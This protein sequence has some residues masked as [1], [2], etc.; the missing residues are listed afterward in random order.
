MRRARFFSIVSSVIA[1]LLVWLAISP[2]A[3]F[4]QADSRPEMAVVVADSSSVREAEEVIPLAMSLIGLLA[5]QQEGDVVFLDTNRPGE[6]VGP[7]S[8][9]TTTTRAPERDRARLESES[10]IASRHSGGAGR[11]PDRPFRRTELPQVQ[12]STWR[13]EARETLATKHWAAPLRLWWT[14][15]PNKVGRSRA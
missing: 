6:A 8:A 12:R 15:S 7:F 10:T 4:A 11:S 5:T 13:W 2:P 1:V 14:A 3:A 9:S